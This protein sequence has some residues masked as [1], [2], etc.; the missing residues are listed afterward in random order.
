MTDIKM[1]EVF[2]LPVFIQKRSTVL[3]DQNGDCFRE[4]EGANQAAVHA[5]NQH[6]KLVEENER[7][8]EENI[9]LLCLL[10]RLAE[11]ASECDGWESFPSPILDEVFEVLNRT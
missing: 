11:T 1:S 3:R 9:K 10:Q 6:D 4:I 8:V 7:L 2:E 5:I